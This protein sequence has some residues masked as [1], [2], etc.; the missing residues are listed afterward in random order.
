[1][2][3]KAIN[4]MKKS[5]FAAGLTAL[6]FAAAVCQSPT[7]LHAQTQSQYAQAQQQP[8]PQQKNQMFS[9]KIMPLKN[10]HYALVTGKGPQGQLVGH[11]VDDT[12]EAS[13]YSGKAVMVT[14]TLN[15]ANNTVHVSKIQP[16]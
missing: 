11:F 10:G 1:M 16:R 12:K 7:L 15:M 14:G 3:R 5:P 2:E 4:T 6:L 9:G 13:K 8:A